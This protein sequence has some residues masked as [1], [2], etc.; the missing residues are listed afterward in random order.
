MRASPARVTFLG[1]TEKNVGTQAGLLETGFCLCT[2]QGVEMRKPPHDRPI[3]RLSHLSRV[4]PVGNG[5]RRADESRTGEWAS[6]IGR[7]D[8]P[9]CSR[10]YFQSR[11]LVIPTVM[12]TG[13]HHKAVPYVAAIVGAILAVVCLIA[14]ALN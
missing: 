13:H 7:L 11:F 8:V 2:S 12:S 3:H 1:F 10:R 9:R 14:W 4:L 5:R 6:R